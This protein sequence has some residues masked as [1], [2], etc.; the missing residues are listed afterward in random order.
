MS[1]LEHLNLGYNCLQRAPTLG[2]SARAK[3]VTLVL[4][5]NELETINGKLNSYIV[6]VLL[7]LFFKAFLSQIRDRITKQ[8]EEENWKNGKL[9]H[10]QLFS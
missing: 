5:N 9:P 3:L 1:E 4:R 7:V 2:Q 8:P 6:R 10:C